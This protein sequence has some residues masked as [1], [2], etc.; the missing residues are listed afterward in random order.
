LKGRYYMGP[1]TN[2]IGSIEGQQ[3]QGGMPGPGTVTVGGRL[4]SRGGRLVQMPPNQLLLHIGL[5][6]GVSPEVAQNP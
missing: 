6:E 1:Q 3:A 2:P 5:A 4:R